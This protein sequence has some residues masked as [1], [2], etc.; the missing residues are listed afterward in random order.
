MHRHPPLPA[1]IPQDGQVDYSRG[2]GRV[3]LIAGSP[4]TLVAIH[5]ATHVANQIVLTAA[6]SIR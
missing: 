2:G 4:G 1:A 6:G 3:A 5:V